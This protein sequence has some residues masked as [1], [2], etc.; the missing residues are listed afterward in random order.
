[1]NAIFISLFSCHASVSQHPTG[2]LIFPPLVGEGQG[3]V[4]CEH[5]TMRVANPLLTSPY[6]GEEFVWHDRQNQHVHKNCE[7]AE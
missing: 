7:M 6:Q 3:G 5:P 2:R 4:G 1:M